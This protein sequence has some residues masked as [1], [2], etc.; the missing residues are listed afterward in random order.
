MIINIRKSDILLIPTR[1]LH[2]DLASLDS[3]MIIF[4][5]QVDL[6]CGR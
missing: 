6:L 2:L 5:E 3:V 4:I 1:K